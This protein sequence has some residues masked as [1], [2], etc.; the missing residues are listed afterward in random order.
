MAQSTPNRS[1]AWMRTK[2]YLMMLLAVL[3]WMFVIL[4]VCGIFAGG[5]AFG[6][7]A[8]LVQDDPVRSEALIRQE[9]SKNDLTGFVYFNDEETLVGQLRGI[10]RRLIT[11]INEVPQV[12]IDAVLA[13]EDDDF[14][15]HFGVDVFGFL[16]AL[17]EQILN[18]PVQTGGST[19]TQ[20]VARNVFLTLDRTVERKAKELLLAIRLERFLSKD[21]ILL[22]YL[23][24]VPFG[25]GS[26]GYN[27]YGIKAAAMGIFGIEDLSDINIAQA[28]YLA[29]LPQDPTDYSAFDGY[30]QFD[31]EGFNK[32]MERQRHVLNRML[33]VGAIT[34]EEY[35]E[36]L[37]FD[38]KASLAEPKPK[39]YSTY[40]FLMLEAEK[41]A[42]EILLLQ[43]NPDLTLQDLRSDEYAQLVNN[44][45]EEL[46]GK[47]YHI[48][49]TIDKEIYD[50]MQEIA[51]NP[52]NFSPDHEEKGIEQVGAVMIDNA[53]G[54][55][56]GMI[57]GRDFYVEQLNHATQMIRQPGSTMKP[58]AAYLP[59]I[60]MGYIQPA[61]I[62]EDSPI[63]LE[64]GSKG[65]HLPNNWNYR[66]KGLVTARYA[67]NQSLNIPAI[68]LFNEVVGVEN[69]WNFV[70][71]LGITTIT[72]QD[73][74]ARTG[75]IGGLAYGT[76]VEELTNAYA[77]IPAG[78]VF[79]DAFMIKRIEDS[80][81]NII[82][83]H[84]VVDKQVYSEETAYLMTDMLKTVISH[85][86]GTSI[87]S[88]FKNYG[89]IEVAGKTGS[90]QNDH[91]AWFVGFSP[92]VTVGVWIGYDQPSTLLLSE[93]AGHR[94]KNIWSLIMDGAIEL[95]PE[96]FDTATFEK[97][98]NIISM[99][100][101]SVSGLL[102][103]D[104]N[105]ELGQLTTDLFDRTKI[106]DKEDN[107]VVETPYVRYKGLNYLPNENTPPDMVK[108]KTFIVRDLDIYELLSRIDTIL[109]ELP[110]NLVPKK[111][112][113]PMTV[114][115]YYPED[116]AQTAPRYPLP[117]VSDDGPPNPPTQLKLE[118]GE[119]NTYII[120][121]QNSDSEDVLGYRFYRSVN[122]EPFSLVN[123]KVVI[124][125]DYPAFYVEQ[126]PSNDYAYYLTAVDVSGHESAP[127]GIV[128]SDPGIADELPPPDAPDDT[129]E[130]DGND[131]NRGHRGDGAPEDEGRD[132]DSDSEDNGGNH[133][134]SGN[135]PDELTPSAPQDVSVRTGEDG[136]SVEIS[137]SA[138]PAAE[139]VRQYIVYFSS[140]EE[141]PFTNIGK[142]NTTRFHHITI[143]LEGWYRVT[144]VNGAGES[145]PSSPVRFRPDSE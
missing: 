59:A 143:P 46:L 48:Y 106:P 55:I 9:I 26:S 29:G 84:E 65:Y 125:G 33:E 58:L 52:E 79:R 16:R 128:V 94:A 43:Q 112:G 138:N 39:A 37:A 96:L 116:I 23:N 90:T 109:K 40:P 31:E 5:T 145:P 124:N 74:Y 68:R 66:F 24:K 67:L 54:A 64:D 42:A 108:Q 120:T 38:I 110:P 101:S 87:K 82:Y 70:K 10:D 63:I 117:E 72:D 80:E 12:I 121:F 1:N 19:I 134:P 131:G 86:T 45:R 93:G 83:E 139:S 92:E 49:T 99:T 95:K 111:R 133:A 76:T 11:N 6:Y 102:P 27:V 22:A 8:S 89:K 73:Y 122:G 60:E 57:E 91:D 144:A 69:A 142:S 51:R 62:I 132:E 97:P 98:E 18:E 105:R 137:W 17:K 107:H 34:R 71:E 41:Q 135:V 104:K 56:L 75:V 13:V 123:G 103:S 118:K 78:G 2:K 3:K 129:Q 53:T 119:G 136:L 15:N 36:A 141:G 44:A 130:D 85:G 20:Q 81:G 14:Y 21:E 126:N 35:E 113:A 100:V 140:S 50:M 127:S 77:S 32:A 47:G 28:A 7:F 4:L 61:S 25:N 30:G 115:D 88:T 114:R